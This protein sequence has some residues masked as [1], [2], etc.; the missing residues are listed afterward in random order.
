MTSPGG[1][2]TPGPT[3]PP[4]ASPAPAPPASAGSGGSAASGAPAAPAAPAAAKLSAESLAALS[5]ALECENAAVWS[6][7]LVAAQDA[8]DAEL[9]TTIVN[10]HLA[11]RDAT[12]SLLRAAGG[13]PA[14]QA[15]A[16][17]VPIAVKDQGSARALATLLENDCAAVWNAVVGTTDLADLRGIALAGLSDSAVWLTQIRLAG[18]VTPPTPPVPRVEVRN[19]FAAGRWISSPGPPRSPS[20]PPAPGEPGSHRRC[21]GP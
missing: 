14:G 7:G 17:S 11:R 6:Y 19:E 3:P 21:A 9:L 1:P 12:A 5:A 2:G 8:A 15:P 18:K 13:K 16:Y 4:G 10:G 20:R